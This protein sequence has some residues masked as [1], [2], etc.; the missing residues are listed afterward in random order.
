MATRTESGGGWTAV[1]TYNDI[2]TAHIAAG[3]LEAQGIPVQLTN[4]TLAGVYPMTDTW[5]AIDMLVPASMAET[6][7]RLLK[8]SGD[9]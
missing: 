7:N 2:N 6:A 1:A 3:M 5:A 4:A 9:K 8:L